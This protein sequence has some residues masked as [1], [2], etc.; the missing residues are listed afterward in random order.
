MTSLLIA[1]VA[2]L[3]SGCATSSSDTPWPTQPDFE[4]LRAEARGQASPGPQGTEWSPREPEGDELAAEERD[5][6]STWGGVLAED[7]DEEEP[8]PLRA[9][10]PGLGAAPG[11]RPPGTKPPALR[12]PGTKPPAL[13]P[14]K[15]A[16]PK[17]EPG[18]TDDLGDTDDIDSDPFF[19]DDEDED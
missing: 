19:R 2:V 12:P 13:K 3:A 11:L 15:A 9:G 6:P 14:P 10:T 8:P 4:R 1:G 17:A 18:A 7:P 5:A 16:P